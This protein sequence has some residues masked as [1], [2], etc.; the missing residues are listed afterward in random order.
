MNRLAGTLDIPTL[1]DLGHQ[2]TG[3]DLR[4]PVKKPKG[5][6]LAEDAKAFNSVIRGIHGVA[7]RANA[8]HKVTCKALRRVSL[9][10]K[11][12]TRITRAALVL[13]QMQHG[14]TDLT[15]ITNRHET[16]PR[17]AHCLAPMRGVNGAPFD[18]HPPLVLLD[19]RGKDAMDR[20]R[21]PMNQIGDAAPVFQCRWCTCSIWCRTSLKRP[22]IH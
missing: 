2:N 20:E 16:F 17:R 1:S 12:I 4:H 15:K 18:R 8:L 10:P 19:H 7:E 22:Q 13:L 6:E 21:H 5:G 11:A 14:R 9:D 3:A